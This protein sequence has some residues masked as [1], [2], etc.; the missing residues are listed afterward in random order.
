MSLLCIST[1]ST[2]WSHYQTQPMQVIFGGM[3]LK[4]LIRKYFMH[5]RKVQCMNVLPKA[6]PSFLKLPSDGFIFYIVMCWNSWL[7]INTLIR[8]QCLS[9]EFFA[10]LKVCNVEGL[11]SLVQTTTLNRRKTPV[12][13][14]TLL[15][16]TGSY[17]CQYFSHKDWQVWFKQL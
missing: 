3:L 5:K 16:Y 12:R 4:S 11:K 7:Q 15:N 2:Y 14:V 9:H 6:P 10:K 17:S 13:H 1:I 8:Y